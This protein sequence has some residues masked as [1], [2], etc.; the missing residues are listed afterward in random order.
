MLPFEG[1]DSAVSPYPAYHYGPVKDLE[2]AGNRFTVTAF[3]TGLPDSYIVDLQGSLDGSDWYNITSKTVDYPPATWA[4]FSS[5]DQAPLSRYV[6]V[7][8]HDVQ[9]GSDPTVKVWV[10]I[11]ERV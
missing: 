4:V 2:G 3:S 10:A 8:I 9:G 11:A 6:R 7:S 1:Y 5:T